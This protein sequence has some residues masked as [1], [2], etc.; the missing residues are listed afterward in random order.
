MGQG[1]EMPGLWLLALKGPS[2]TGKSTLGRALG[3]RLGWPVV[4]KD[5]VK[6]VL[7][8]HTPEAGALA[9]E[10]MWSVARRQ[11]MQGL[12]VV[13]DSP[14]T[15][16]LGYDRAKHIAE[17][18]GARLAIIECT[19]PDEV[20]W[21]ERIE[22]RKLLALPAHHQTDWDEFRLSSALLPPAYPIDAPRLV[23]ATIRD[24]ADLVDECLHWLGQ[25]TVD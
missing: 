22:R 23:L 16:A 13:C 14:L 20:I 24:L 19:C 18:A 15:G 11:L 2:G 1:E 7:D 17:E 9:Y 25:L 3:L 5:D 21:R 8:G 12:S 10:V 4:D 6:D